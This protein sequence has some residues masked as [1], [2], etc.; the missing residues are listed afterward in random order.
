MRWHELCRICRRTDDSEEYIYVE[1]P[2]SAVRRIYTMSRYLYDTMW[3]YAGIIR[4]MKG[5]SV[6][7][8]RLWVT[9]VMAYTDTSGGHLR[10]ERRGARSEFFGFNYNIALTDI[11]GIFR[12]IFNEM[13]RAHRS[14]SN[15]HRRDYLWWCNVFNFAPMATAYKSP[16]AWDAAD[17]FFACYL[18]IFTLV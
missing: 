12:G 5:A 9:T 15:I 2:L 1:E 4:S 18:V 3:Q 11:T 8:R 17:L 14:R 6:I 7:L 10:R 16:T 13:A